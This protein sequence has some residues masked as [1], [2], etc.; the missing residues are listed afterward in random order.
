M[1]E[2]TYNY[3]VPFYR[4]GNEL[5]YL[6]VRNRVAFKNLEKQVGGCGQG[7]GVKRRGMPACRKREAGRQAAGPSQPAG[8]PAWLPPRD[9]S[10]CGATL[11]TAAAGPG[12]GGGLQRAGGG[13]ARLHSLHGAE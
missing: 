10:C 3:G 8:A 1:L 13:V 6:K 2:L 7:W 4:R 12:P 11:P 9:G 5:G